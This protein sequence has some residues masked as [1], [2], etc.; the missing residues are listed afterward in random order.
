MIL[1]CV[2]VCMSTHVYAYSVDVPCNAGPGAARRGD[3]GARTVRATAAA[4]V[5]PRGGGGQIGKG[6]QKF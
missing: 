1:S 2:H 3:W 4:A 6:T 5:E